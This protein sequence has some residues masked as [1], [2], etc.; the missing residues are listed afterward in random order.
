MT[1][2]RVRDGIFFSNQANQVKGSCPQFWQEVVKDLS[3]NR[4]DCH[5]IVI[6]HMKQEV[7]YENPDDNLACFRDIMKVLPMLPGTM[8][9]P[10]SGKKL[11]LFFE[12]HP[13]G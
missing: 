6:E 5:G 1:W 7:P 12:L 10:N 3:G 8:N 9:V 2:E 4:T 13:K 11:V